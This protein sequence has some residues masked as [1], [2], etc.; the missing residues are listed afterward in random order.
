MSRLARLDPAEMEGEQ[1]RVYDDIADAGRGGLDG[2]YN[3]LLR[4][5]EIADPAQKLGAYC[6]FRSSLGLKLTE[7][8][9]I[10]T[11]KHY[12]AQFEWH[13]HAALALKAGLSPAIVDAIHAGTPPPFSDEREVAVYDLCR[14]LHEHHR[15]D[16]A[17]YTRAR[18]LFGEA[19][20]VEIVSTIGY[21]SMISLV[22][23]TFEVPVPGNASPPFEI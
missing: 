6:R 10:I 4:V 9:I 22:L 8:A 20:I 14:T 17:T 11:A 15:V 7:L 12:H 5:P 23:N 19:G 18:S 1:K 16:D 2:P 3:A 21:Y 13:A